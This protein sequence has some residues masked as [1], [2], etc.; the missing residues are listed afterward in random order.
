MET[1]LD[2]IQISVAC[3]LLIVGFALTYF[4]LFKQNKPQRCC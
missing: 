4:S 2:I 1:V 3:I